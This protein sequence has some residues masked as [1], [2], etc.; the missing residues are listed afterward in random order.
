MSSRLSKTKNQPMM[1]SIH[2]AN[3]K[4]QNSLINCINKSGRSVYK[5][6]NLPRQKQ[7]HIAIPDNP[8]AVPIIQ[9][10]PN[11]EINFPPETS[12]PPEAPDTNDSLQQQPFQL[13]SFY[14]Y[15]DF[16]IPIEPE[17]PFILSE[18][19]EPEEWFTCD[20]GF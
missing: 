15:S 13:N 16:S 18:Q 9:D 19:L 7:R 5:I 12:F 3:M 10:S 20:Y 2:L 6:T 14:E 11:P 1:L 17:L 8:L 4:G